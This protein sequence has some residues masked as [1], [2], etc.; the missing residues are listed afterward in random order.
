MTLFVLFRALFFGI[1]FTFPVGQLSYQSRGAS[2][3][4]Q[5]LHNRG[6]KK[7]HSG[8]VIL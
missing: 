8:W 5:A 7:E 2:S 4:P 6:S 1:Y 3:H